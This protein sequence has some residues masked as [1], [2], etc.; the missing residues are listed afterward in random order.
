MPRF[1][2]VFEV[3]L[4]EQFEKEKGRWDVHFVKGI[5]KVNKGETPF[6]VLRFAYLYDGNDFI[7]DIDNFDVSFY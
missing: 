1:R 5:P 7:E 6:A 3:L 4:D 2:E